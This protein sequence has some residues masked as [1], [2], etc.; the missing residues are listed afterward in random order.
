M[1]EAGDESLIR[2]TGQLQLYPDGDNLRT[3][4]ALWDLRRARG[5][6]IELLGTDEIRQLEPVIGPHYR[7]GVFLPDEGMVVNPQRQ[8][9]LLSEAFV[10]NGGR[11]L[12]QDVRGFEMG[13]DG[14]TQAILDGERLPVE[15]VVVAAGAWSH[16]LAAQLGSRVPLETQRGY[17]VTIANPGIE[18]KRPVVAADRKCF[19]TP[20]EMGLR[21]AGTVEFAGL[22]APPNHERA[23][24]L[25]EHGRRMFPR[26]HTEER[27]EWMGHRPCLPDSLPVIGRSP[28]YPTV[29][30]AFG[31]GHLGLTGAAVT[32]KHIAAIVAGRRPD[33]DL[34][35]FRIDRF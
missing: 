22:S 27:T 10:R 33:I 34:T 11:I 2:R 15:R 18:L 19:A 23:R 25:I 26:L 28:T 32:G 6:R 1:K 12:R 4:S 35:P 9:D 14:P 17:H 20:M 7:A 5:V 21:L 31:H 13:R 30:Y 16:R 3:D 8:L 29:F 24:A